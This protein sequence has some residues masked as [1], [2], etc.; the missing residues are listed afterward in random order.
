MLRVGGSAGAGAVASG[1]PRG[2]SQ[3]GAVGDG[4]A[5]DGGDNAARRRVGR[6]A[7]G[8]SVAGPPTR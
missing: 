7:A 5:I 1:G 2:G 8:V 3:G 6:R 4:S